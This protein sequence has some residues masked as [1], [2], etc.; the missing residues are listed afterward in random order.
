MEILNIKI[1]YKEI[2]IG[3]ELII[4]SNSNLR[5]LKVLS[6]NPK[7]FTCSTF[8][9]KEQ[10]QGI[11]SGGTYYYT[12]KR[13]FNDNIKEHNKTFYLTDDNDYKDIFLVKRKIRD[14][15]DD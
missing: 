5:Y 15:Y 9:D 1:D 7:S 3:D 13:Y 14:N 2:Q 11:Y 12:R 8:E 6:K 4:P 10:K